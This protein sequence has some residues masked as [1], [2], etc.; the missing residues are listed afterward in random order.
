[1]GCSTSIGNL[2]SCQSPEK[3]GD[4]CQ[5]TQ[6]GIW[7]VANMGGKTEEEVR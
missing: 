1:M 4:L 3:S 6:L 7:C 2:I 5:R